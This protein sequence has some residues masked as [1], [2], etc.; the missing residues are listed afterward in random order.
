MNT[1]DSHPECRQRFLAIGVLGAGRVVTKGRTVMTT[2]ILAV[3][4]FTFAVATPAMAQNRGQPRNNV[5]V[6]Q[7]P[8]NVVP[9]VV[10]VFAPQPAPWFHPWLQPT[11]PI[12]VRQ[13][14]LFV[15]KGPDLL[16]NPVAG[17]VVR[18]LSGVAQLRD[19][20]TFFRVPGSGVVNA[21]GQI[22]TGTESYYNPRAGTFYN[23]RSGV[24][25]RPGFGW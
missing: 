6:L 9:V 4:V 12:A 16:V 2:R 7:P 18:P 17:T 14:G 20:S 15:F 19:G 21:F 1:E 22:E 24:V 25:S 10:P 23:P 8:V 13:P 3:A 11:P 5:V